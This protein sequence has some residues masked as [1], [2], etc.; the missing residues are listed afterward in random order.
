MLASV[1]RASNLETLVLA[2]ALFGPF[3]LPGRIKALGQGFGFLVLALWL[4]RAADQRG[5]RI[6]AGGIA[7]AGLGILAAGIAIVLR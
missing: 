5:I 6:T 4:W 2:V 1:R 3:F 7:I